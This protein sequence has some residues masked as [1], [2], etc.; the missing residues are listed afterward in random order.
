[1]CSSDHAAS[2]KTLVAY[3]EARD[4]APSAVSELASWLAERIPSYMIPSAF[5]PMEALPMN[6]NGKVDRK[7]LPEPVFEPRS[8][9]GPRDDMAR[10]QS[11]TA[12]CRNRV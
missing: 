4:G 12:S 1:M 3:F 11:G 8:A 10:L 9:G 6:A 2:G 5:V 7:K